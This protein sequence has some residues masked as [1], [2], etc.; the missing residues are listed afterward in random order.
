M[1]HQSSI[2]ELFTYNNIVKFSA[3]LFNEASFLQ[4]L[5]SKQS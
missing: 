4:H 3:S 2:T 1:F 5:Q